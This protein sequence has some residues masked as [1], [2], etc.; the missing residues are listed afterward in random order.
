MASFVIHHVEGLKFWDKLENEYGISL[1]EKE[2]NYSTICFFDNFL[3]QIDNHVLS[4]ICLC[5][6]I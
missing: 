6:I 3:L 1:N 2:K 4:I 5:D